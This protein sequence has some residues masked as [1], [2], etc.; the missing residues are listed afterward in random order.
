MQDR[1]RDIFIALIDA[2][3]D[4]SSL[5]AFIEGESE[6]TQA[7]L[8]ALAG[9]ANLAELV[10]Q[11]RADREA[12]RADAAA[13]PLPA[14]TLAMV[15][16]V[17]DQEIAE[18]YDADE[19]RA[20]EQTGVASTGVR[21]PAHPAAKGRSGRA[22]GRPYG[23]SR[24]PRILGSLAAAAVIIITVGVIV[25]NL[26]YA[27]LPSEAEREM[28][29]NASPNAD[30]GAA[31]FGAPLTEEP[32]LAQAEPSSE[33]AEIRPRP[34]ERPALV[35]TP[36]EALR[37]AREGRLLVRLTS[38]RESTSLALAEDLT[39]GSELMRFA[40]IEGR[41]SPEEALAYEAALPSQE[42]PV[43]ASDGRAEPGPVLRAERHSVGSYMLRVEPTER[44]FTMLLSKLR[45]YP[46]VSV[47]LVGSVKAVTTPT[48]AADISNL[49]Q[50]P[51][52]W[53][54]RI[55]VPVVVDTIR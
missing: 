33:N 5:N 47:E 25:P 10:W 42:A 13:R 32:Q 43:M 15:G 37:L 27:P 21:R 40:V 6:A 28:A 14:E 45:A 11:L 44:S 20:I 1:E 22:R 29:S 8:E 9:D 51:T 2:G 54:S 53:T 26:E 41:V 48:T 46:G 3:L 52:R 16:A 19:L 35:E 38:V 18:S 39:T 31:E 49:S 17:L 4:E 55:S 34:L 30:E 24:L 7:V 12:L 23:S 50:S 36:A